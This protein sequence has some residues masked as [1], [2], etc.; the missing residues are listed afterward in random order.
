MRA[1]GSAYLFFLAGVQLSLAMGYVISNKWPVGW[2]EIALSL[3]M[4][5]GVVAGALIQY[6][7]GWVP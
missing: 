1:L 5:G 7:L 3:V 2:P 4:I 6:R